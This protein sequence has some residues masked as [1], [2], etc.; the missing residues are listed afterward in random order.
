VWPFF[1]EK[2]RFYHLWGGE[3]FFSTEEKC[4]LIGSGEYGV[5]SKDI[6][7]RVGPSQR[8]ENM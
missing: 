4:Y 1:E 7:V 6:V 5:K 2:K 8:A 3:Q